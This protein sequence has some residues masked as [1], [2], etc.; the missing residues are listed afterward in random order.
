MSPLRQTKK[1]LTFKPLT[2]REWPDFIRLFE[3]HGPQN[4]CWCM[5][6]RRT[7]VEWQRGFGEGNKRA[8]RAIVDG[9]KKPGILA[10]HQGR[11]VA[12]CAIAPREDCGALERSRTLKRVDRMPV[13]SITWFFVLKAYRQRGMTGL[14][15]EAAIDHARTQGAKVVEAYPLRTQIS[16][17]LP[18]ER[19]MGIQSTFEQAGFKEV[20]SR[21][22]RR[23]I[24]RYCVR[25]GTRRGASQARVGSRHTTR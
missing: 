24:L 8:F 14:L 11:A 5:Y 2:A 23:P 22:E 20:A 21:S 19:Y 10:Y 17:L 9:G 16:K 15:I 18:Y 6:W 25:G 7:R 13:W 3:E 1:E 12:W 4:G